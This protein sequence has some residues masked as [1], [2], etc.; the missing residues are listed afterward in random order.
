MK[1][2]AALLAVSLLVCGCPSFLRQTDKN[3][4][5]SG[6][7][8]WAYHDAR[9]K[10]LCLEEV[11]PPTCTGYKT[12]LDALSWQ[13]VAGNKVQQEGGL[14]SEERSA[15]KKAKKAVSKNAVPGIPVVKKVTP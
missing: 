12:A 15:I 9:Y 2:A 8:A 10:S 13:N 14:P 4:V 6:H 1:R 7:A 3:L 5:A 11:G